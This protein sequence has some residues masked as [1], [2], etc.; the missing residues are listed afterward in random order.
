MERFWSTS[1]D[2]TYYPKGSNADVWRQNNFS[3]GINAPEMLSPELRNLINQLSISANPVSPEQVKIGGVYILGSKIFRLKEGRVESQASIHKTSKT[4]V[5]KKIVGD[6]LDESGKIVEEIRKVDFALLAPFNKFLREVTDAKY[7]AKVAKE[8][9]PLP[10]AG[11]APAGIESAASAELAANTSEKVETQIRPVAE[12]VCGRQVFDTNLDLH[13]LKKLSSERKVEILFSYIH[14]RQQ[15]IAQNSEY[16]SKPIPPIFFRWK[17]D[18]GRFNVLC[19]YDYKRENQ[20][21]KAGLAKGQPENHPQIKGKGVDGETLFEMFAQL[22]P[23][24]DLPTEPKME[25]PPEPSQKTDLTPA[26]RDVLDSININIDGVQWGISHVTG[27]KF[28]DKS[29]NS[30]EDLCRKIIHAFLVQNKTIAK[31]MI[32]INISVNNADFTFGISKVHEHLNEY[33]VE[34]YFL[35]EKSGRQDFN[36]LGARGMAAK[37]KQLVGNA[38]FKNSSVSSEASVNP[39]ATIPAAKAA[40]QSQPPEKEKPQNSLVLKIEGVDWVFEDTENLGILDENV[41]IL[42]DVI[43][44]MIRVLNLKKNSEGDEVSIQVGFNI[45]GHKSIFGL[46]SAEDGRIEGFLW[47]SSGFD[48]IEA[49]DADDFAAQIKKLVQENFEQTD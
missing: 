31:N 3:R 8:N 47:G 43:Q 49:S 37:M 10:N 13:R 28:I 44:N 29:I 34:L 25:N 41:K 36:V 2:Q 19:L 30:L 16:K 32:L 35:N 33:R 38:S 12:V 42:E 15:M 48:E 1:W 39:S 6:I 46:A 11:S 45:N 4:F 18:D 20:T 40:K 5:F 14:R 7:L 17:R 22:A 9:T 26:E 21:F 27:A 24:A 23:T